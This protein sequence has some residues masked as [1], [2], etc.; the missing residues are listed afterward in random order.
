MNADTIRA[1]A[2][3][4]QMVLGTL[5]LVIISAA[6]V[7]ML[8]GGQLNR[9]TT[10][11]MEPTYA[12]G[13]WVLTLPPT[14]A[15]LQVGQAVGVALDDGYKYTHRVVAVEDG[16]ATLQGDANPLPDANTVTQDDVWGVPVNNISGPAARLLDSFV[17]DPQRFGTGG[18][19]WGLAAVLL[20]AVLAFW[21]LPRIANEVEYRSDLRAWRESEA[22]SAD[23]TSA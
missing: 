4:F 22:A 18:F 21:G 9:V 6:A 11:S 10:G 1:A 19:P 16:V 13:S 15:D 20:F 17:V 8:L 2:R 3:G 12:T 14:G 7:L 5:L 23:S